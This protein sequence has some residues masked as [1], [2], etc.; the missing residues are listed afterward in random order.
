MNASATRGAGEATWSAVSWIMRDQ[1]QPGRASSRCGSHS[2]ALW[3][4]ASAVTVQPAGHAAAEVL[5]IVPDLPGIDVPL[6]AVAVP[7][8]D[9]ERVRRR[10]I[11]AQI[12]ERTHRVQKGDFSDFVEVTDDERAAG[13]L[14]G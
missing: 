13:R 3:G 11:A 4:Y 12:R 1:A 5:H 6:G 9:Y 8:E 10:A 14:S 2:F 7:V